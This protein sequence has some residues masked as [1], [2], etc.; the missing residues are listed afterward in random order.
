VRLLPPHSFEL[1]SSSA[2]ISKFRCQ[3]SRLRNKTGC[4]LSAAS[5]SLSLSL[6]LLSLYFW[7]WPF[8]SS[9]IPSFA[10]LSFS[11]SSS[12][13]S[14]CRCPFTEP[15]FFLPCSAQTQTPSSAHLPISPE[16]QSQFITIFVCRVATAPLCLDRLLVFASHRSLFFP[17]GFVDSDICKYL[18]CLPS[19]TFRPK[20]S[21]GFRRRRSVQT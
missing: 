10:H 6:S 13:S 3:P 9:L 1:Q 14:S 7:W 12:S 2:G 11:S 15:P 20:P 18:L 17:A 4:Q 19:S 5:L 8:A 16:N 21:S